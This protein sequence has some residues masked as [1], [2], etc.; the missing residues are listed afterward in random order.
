[1]ILQRLLQ[2]AV[3]AFAFICGGMA[4]AAS[5]AARNPYEAAPAKTSESRIDEL[6]FAQLRTLGIEPAPVCS[7][8]VFVRRAFLDVIGTL[9]TATEAREFIRSAAPGKR[10]AL[11]DVLLA[12]DEFAD[13]WAMK[14]SDLLRIKAEFPINLWP[15][16]AQAYHRFVYAAVRDN[17]R[18]DEFARRLLVSNGSNFHD[19]PANFF[20]AVSSHEPA[21][22][23]RSAA[24]AFMGMRAEQWPAEKLAG[25]AAFFSAVSFKPTGEWKEEIV[26]FDPEKTPASGVL[27]D[28]T[29][30]VLT[31]GRD[32][33]A[34][35]CDWLLDPKHPQF[36]QAIA[37]RTWSWL[38]GRGIVDEPD[39]FRPDNPPSNPELLSYL[40]TEL[41]ASGYDIKQLMR[42]ILTSEVYQ[43]SSIA[44]DTRPE[45][46]VH[47]A[48]YPP[49]R[50]DAEILIDALDEITGTTETY[51][52]P[53]PEPFTI[54]PADVRSIALPD[55]SIT[56]SFLEV[57]GRPSRDTGFES[58]RNN[59]ITATQRLQLLNSTQVQRKIEQGPR[60]QAL[61]RV[62]ADPRATIEE[63]YYTILS[64]APTA[65]ETQI[66]LDYARKAGTGPRNAVVDLTWALINSAEF[67][68]RH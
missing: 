32:P 33:R 58:E 54:V 26:F 34:V 66:A 48:S 30:V 1:M 24:L 10:T 2:S 41:V 68:Y 56:S 47:F 13:R 28:G 50:L 39:D 20:R 31:P 17:L 19:G 37:N 7:D 49:R 44:R 51:S 38:L 57:F 3:A 65:A 59:R 18:C 21:V 46:A 61:F 64:R 15:N 12:R 60:L 40:A 11:I 63:L 22:L 16:A 36:A 25:F 35:F 67:L 42:L 6:V 23:A 55:G 14:W 62:R 52:S 43:L 27:P 8:A 9:P 45:A 29:R 5:E 53:I 4:R